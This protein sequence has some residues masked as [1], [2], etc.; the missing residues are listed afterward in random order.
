MNSKITIKVIDQSYLKQISTLGQQLNPQLTLEQTEAYFL[1]MFE[2]RN[3]TCFGLFLEEKLVGISSAW[4]TVR[5]YS[6]KQLEVD[7]VIIDN[8]QQSKGLGKKFFEFIE[9]WARER[10]YKTIELNTYVQNAKSHKFYFNLGYNILG[11]HFLK[12][13]K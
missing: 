3:Y 6:G 12:K 1:E 10:N 2:F 13:L 8:A 5:L 7:N 9:N 4:T 11:F